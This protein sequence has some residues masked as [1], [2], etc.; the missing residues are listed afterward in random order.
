MYS[1]HA[2]AYGCCQDAQ[3]A[4]WEEFVSWF[5]SKWLGWRFIAEYVV[6]Q[7]C[8]LPSKGRVTL[9]L[10]HYTELHDSETVLQPAFVLY[11]LSTTTRF[12]D[13][14]IHLANLAE[15]FGVR[16][17]NQQQDSVRIDTKIWKWGSCA[18][19]CGCGSL[20]LK[21]RLGDLPPKHCKDNRASVS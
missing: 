13:P 12:L 20:R 7:Q 3:T 16:M 19:C 8:P 14:K 11:G 6:Q 17:V 1:M 2:L 18:R 10:Y 15:F 9:T 5:L 21:E 4:F